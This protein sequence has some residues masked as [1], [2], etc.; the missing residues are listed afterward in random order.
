MLF[1][2]RVFL[3]IFL[4]GEDEDDILRISTRIGEICLKYGAID[5]FLPDSVK[6]KRVLLD[7][8]EK[9]G[10]A[11]RRCQVLDS[12][13]IV[14]PRSHIADFMEKARERANAYGMKI[15]AFGHAGD[16]NLHLYVIKQGNSIEEEKGHEHDQNLSSQFGED[17]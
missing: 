2:F 17:P 11:L 16:G 7:L 8:R 5:I 13:D 12:F 6:A 10:P 4:E 3:M 1:P 15:M 9:F 14:V